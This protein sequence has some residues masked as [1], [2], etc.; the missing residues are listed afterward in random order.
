MTTVRE[1]DSFDSIP[2]SN[3]EVSPITPPPVVNSLPEKC[4]KSVNTDYA[5][6]LVRN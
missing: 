1:K 3:L 2:E 6:L 4:D 5:Y